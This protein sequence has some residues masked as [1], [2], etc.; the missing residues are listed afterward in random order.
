MCIGPGSLVGSPC[1]PVL[2]FNLIP[3][4]PLPSPDIRLPSWRNH[5]TKAVTPGSSWLASAGGSSGTVEKDPE[6]SGCTSALAWEAGAA[7]VD[8]W[9]G[10]PLKMQE[11]FFKA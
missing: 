10:Q 9:C 7:V 1:P 2:E 6:V 8:T 3:A 4:R 11:I 5:A